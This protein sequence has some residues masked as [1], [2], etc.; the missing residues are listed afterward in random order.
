M[1]WLSSR[2]VITNASDP[3]KRNAQRLYGQATCSEHS[4]MLLILL[5]WPQFCSPKYLA[6]SG[7]TSSTVSK[8][9]SI[10]CRSMCRLKLTK[11]Y[12]RCPKF[13]VTLP[14]KYCQEIRFT[15][16]NTGKIIGFCMLH[17]TL[18]MTL[19]VDPLSR[20]YFCLCS[21]R[22]TAFNVLGCSSL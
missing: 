16:N 21:A 17:Q 12:S 22:K 13:R 5:M 3:V 4:V 6:I 19:E 8:M 1:E 7:N 14:A 2:E 11:L 10:K 20:V 9:L 15:F 18:T